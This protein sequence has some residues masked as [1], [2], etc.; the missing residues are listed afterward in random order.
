MPNTWLEQV[1]K[2]D[3]E[4]FTNLIP[5]GRGGTYS[6]APFYQGLKPVAKGPLVSQASRSAR[7]AQILQ[8]GESAIPLAD[9]P[10]DV[11]LHPG[12]VSSNAPSIIVG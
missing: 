6:Y 5:G 9:E 3:A 1:G 8:F 2:G 12:D 7:D 4:F 10:G 11:A